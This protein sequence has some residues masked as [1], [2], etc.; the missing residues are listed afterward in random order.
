VGDGVRRWRGHGGR[1]CG[2][3]SLERVWWGLS[4]RSKG[5]GGGV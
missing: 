2:A 3:Q 5:G 1:G 4:G